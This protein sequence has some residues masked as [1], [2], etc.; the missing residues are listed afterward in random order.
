MQELTT[1]PAQEADEPA[2]KSRHRKRALK[3][4]QTGVSTAP[5]P[6]DER[7]KELFEMLKQRRKELASTH[8]LAAYVIAH[9][10]ALEELARHQPLDSDGLLFIK[11]IGPAK[12][13]KYGE[14]WIKVIAQFKR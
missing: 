1:E 10:T 6:L 7:E 5:I 14:D 4:V 9:N 12:A 8:G 13:E 3:T 2:K 11:G